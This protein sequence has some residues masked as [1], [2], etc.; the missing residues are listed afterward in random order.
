M[1]KMMAISSLV[2]SPALRLAWLVVVELAVAD[3][4]EAIC[5]VERTH[6]EVNDGDGFEVDAGGIVEEDVDT[7]AGGAAAEVD[8]AA[9]SCGV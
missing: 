4:L 6:E 7:E 8:G 9:S 3:V 1:P 2:F 5:V